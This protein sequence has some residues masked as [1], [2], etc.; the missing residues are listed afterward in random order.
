MLSVVAAVVAPLLELLSGATLSKACPLCVAVVVVTHF[1]QHLY[2]ATLPQLRLRL[3]PWRD[4]C[5]G[6]ALHDDRSRFL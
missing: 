5:C 1:H 2:H 4:V 3:L 6:A